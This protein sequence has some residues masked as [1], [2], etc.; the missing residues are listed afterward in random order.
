M[1]TK[2]KQITVKEFTTPLQG[3]TPLGQGCKEVQVQV[4][5]T[6]ILLSMVRPTDFVMSIDWKYAFFHCPVRVRHRK[7]KSFYRGNVT[8]MSP[9]R[10]QTLPDHLIT[11]RKYGARCASA[12][13]ALGWRGIWTIC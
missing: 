1:Y 7:Y 9:L 12:Q 10:V 3:K 5:K 13:K 4:I 11:M 8:Y 6:H 2:L